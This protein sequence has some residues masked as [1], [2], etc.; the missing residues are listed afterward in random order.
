MLD[1]RGILAKPCDTV[2][3]PLRHEA[4]Q[5]CA[6][7]SSNPHSESLVVPTDAEGEVPVRSLLLQLQAQS[8]TLRQT[9]PD[10]LGERTVT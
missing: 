10:E 4:A 5:T 6:T 9:Q 7:P 3:P 8:K 1:Q 2:L